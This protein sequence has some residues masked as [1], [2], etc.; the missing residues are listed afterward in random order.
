[1]A[2]QVKNPI[3]IHEEVGLI[4]GLTQG[5]KECCR[6]GHRCG[7]HLA[8]LGLGLQMQLPFHPQPGNSMCSLKKKKNTSSMTEELNF[9]LILI[10]KCK[11]IYL[12]L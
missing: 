5:V 4:P 11:H 1:M 12:D 2:Q 3:S 8:L 6:K 9:N 10:L 7:S